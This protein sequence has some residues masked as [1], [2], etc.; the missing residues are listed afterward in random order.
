MDMGK[1]EDFLKTLPSKQTRK[2]YSHGLRI[3]EQFLGKSIEEIQP[4]EAN[5]L[6]EQFFVWL[7]EKGYSQNSAR[8]FTSSVIQYLRFLDYPL[9]IRK[10][11]G[12][13][14]Q[15][16]TY[17]DHLLTI[18]EVRKMFEVADLREKI[19]LEIFVRGLRSSDACSLE[20]KTFDVEGEC[21]IEISIYTKKEGIPNRTFISQEFK[22]LLNQYLPLLDKN[23]PY[24]FQT[25]KGHLCP[26]RLDGIIKDLFKRAG[27]KA[28]GSIRWHLGRKLFTRVCAQIGIP[29]WNTK[30]MLGKQIPIND[31]TYVQGVDLT[32]DF[33]KLS[34]ALALRQTSTNNKVNNLEEAID[35][36]LKALKK[37]IIQQG[38]NLQTTK[39]MSE[40]EFIEA[41]VNARILSSEE[42]SKKKAS[43]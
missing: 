16:M 19:I 12:I 31:L 14:R 32:E 42:I 39:E 6:I 27:L 29:T 13:Y 38:F 22:E 7:K 30:I 21:P 17:R 26:K 18:D 3:F 15:E 33:R 1:L 40:K 35:L 9:K 24:L 43:F 20:W 28:K 25:K 11:L 23:N 37:L 36:V 5:K 10:S 41:F 4:S 8:I 34:N 2:T